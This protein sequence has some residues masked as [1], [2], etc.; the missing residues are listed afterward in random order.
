MEFKPLRSQVLQ[1]K[2]EQWIISSSSFITQQLF[3]VMH[4]RKTGAL[5]CKV[6][7]APVETLL[8]TSHIYYT[9]SMFTSDICS[10]GQH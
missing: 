3:D 10:I 2:Y 5:N 7:K 1:T 9:I 6:L 8:L 4:S